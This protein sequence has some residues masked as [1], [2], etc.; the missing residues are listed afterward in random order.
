M[1][2]ICSII[3]ICSIFGAAIILIA[4]LLS[5][6]KLSGVTLNILLTF[7]VLGIAGAVASTSIALIQDGKKVANIGLI[8]ILISAVLI[9]LYVWDV[10]S[11][12]GAGKVVEN[13]TIIISVLSIFV[14]IS[15]SIGIKLGRNLLAIQ[16]ICYACLVILNCYIDYAVISGSSNITILVIIAIIALAL[17]CYLQ[18]M[19]KKKVD[20]KIVSVGKEKVVISKIEYETMQ[21]KIKELEAEISR[22]KE[23]D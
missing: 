9:L 15:L 12:I 13:A 5:W 23:S 10:M 17:I 1:K 22:L 14:S 11:K 6:L 18:Y 8:L 21:N 20:E 7:V 2:K 3:T 16:I 19:G 4:S